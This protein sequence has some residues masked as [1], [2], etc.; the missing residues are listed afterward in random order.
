[1][2][3]PT[4]PTD[5]LV[6]SDSV[7]LPDATLAPAI[8]GL[9]ARFFRD[10]ADYEPLAEV[11]AAAMRADGVPYLPTA[12]NLRIDMESNEGSN[13]FEDV[14]L[15]EVD[16]RLVALATVERRVRD[17]IPT[18]QIDGQVHPDHRRRGIGRLAVRLEHRTIEGACGAR[19]SERPSQ[20]DSVRRGCRSRGPGA[21]RPGRVRAGPPLLPDAT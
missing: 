11:I 10:D 13:R 21:F 2:T 5:T 15:V 1:M 14:V 16:G 6:G 4:R 20:V 18:Y 17:D 12:N 3:A 9:R 8:P 7:P 19:G